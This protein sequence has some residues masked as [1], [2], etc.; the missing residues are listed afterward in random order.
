VFDKVIKTSHRLTMIVQKMVVSLKKFMQ[1]IAGKKAP[2]QQLYH[3]P[4]FLRLELLSQK[5]LGRTNWRRTNVGDGAVRT[6]MVD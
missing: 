3:I 2:N 6:I 1:Q 4:C 5:P